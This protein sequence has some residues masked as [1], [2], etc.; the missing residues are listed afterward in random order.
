LNALRRVKASST[1]ITPAATYRRVFGMR[2]VAE[3]WMEAGER[4]AHALTGREMLPRA[5]SHA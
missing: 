2:Q 5:H 4:V 3:P 1:M